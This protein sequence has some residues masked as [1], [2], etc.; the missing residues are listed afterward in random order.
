M[1]ETQRWSVTYTNHVKQKRKVYHDGFLTVQSSR[2]K[3]MLYDEWDKLLETRFV[4]KDDLI[5]SGETI[6]FGSYLVDLG[7]LCQ[8]HQPISNLNSQ[9]QDKKVETSSSHYSY[10]SQNRKPM[11]GKRKGQVVNISPS[12][13]MIRD[14][15]KSEVN[16]FSSSPSCMNMTKLST[17]E[18]Q[19]L[20]TTQI[21]QKAKKFHDGFLH[22]IIHGSQG[23]Q[24]K[25]YDINRRHLDGRFL[26]KD[27]KVCSGESL[28]LDGHLVEI[29]EQEEDHKPPTDLN[30]QGKGCKVTGKSDV[31]DYQ[32]KIPTIK[33]FPAGKTLGG[34]SQGTF[35]KFSD[36][37]YKS[38]NAKLCG[39]DAE[40]SDSSHKSENAKLCGGDA[41]PRR[42]VCDILSI[43]RQSSERKVVSVNKPFT[44]DCA[45]LYPSKSQSGNDNHIK[46]YAEECSGTARL[47]LKQKGS[48]H[49]S[50]IKVIKSEAVEVVIKTEKHAIPENGRVRQARSSS[51]HL[52]PQTVNFKSPLHDVRSSSMES[53]AAAAAAV[54]ADSQRDVVSESLTRTYDN[55]ELENICPCEEVVTE[56]NAAL[57]NGSS[58]SKLPEED[59]KGSSSRCNVASTTSASRNL[60]ETSLKTKDMDEIPSFD[61][62]F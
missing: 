7:E 35:T 60:K 44:K 15:K 25:L 36:S 56:S 41:E 10:N 26:K 11:V 19:V 6:T 40:P 14:F 62:G 16:K 17:K 58:S 57:A 8:G 52:R 23:R 42:S 29:G 37:S 45:E 53:H 3:V 1:E 46:K 38:E 24:V 48:E 22:L 31:V 2:N 20:Y 13:K 55:Q 5:L 47:E 51:F 12:Q 33:K 50:M 32:T 49:D 21:T 61:L 4:K 54:N 27:E 43:L 28:V 18:W 59:K 39:R 30:I 34:T 9:D